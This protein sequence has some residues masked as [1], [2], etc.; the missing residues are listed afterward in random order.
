LT[1]ALTTGMTMN[2]LVFDFRSPKRGLIFATK[3]RAAAM[4]K[5]F[6]HMFKHMYNNVDGMRVVSVCLGALLQPEP[7]ARPTAPLSSAS[8]R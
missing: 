6:A 5:R 7:L 4:C 2:N 1:T 8:E 3:C